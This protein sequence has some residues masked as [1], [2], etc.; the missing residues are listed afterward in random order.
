[1]TAQSFLD[2]AIA[3]REAFKVTVKE[4]A[5]LLESRLVIHGCLPC[6]LDMKALSDHMQDG[7]SDA[8]GDALAK[9]QREAEAEENMTAIRDVMADIADYHSRV[10]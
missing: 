7:L 4:A 9:L 2:L 6:D 8:I 1:M 3:A 10:L 5:A